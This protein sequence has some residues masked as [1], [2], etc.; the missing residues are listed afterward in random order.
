MLYQN[1]TVGKNHGVAPVLEEGVVMYPNTAIIGR[2]MVKE[3]TVLSQGVS[4]LNSDTP[5]NTAVFQGPEGL[6]FKK[7]GRNILLDIFR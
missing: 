6:I 3:N 2:C 5:G 7:I 4:V 1:S